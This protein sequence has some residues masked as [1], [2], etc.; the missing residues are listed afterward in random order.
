MCNKPIQI[1]RIW[2]FPILSSPF[3]VSKIFVIKKVSKKCHFKRW[4]FFDTYYELKQYVI[5]SRMR[6]TKIKKRRLKKK[7]SIILAI[8]NYVINFNGFFIFF[9]LEYKP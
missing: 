2:H 1:A 9:Y 8:I 4:Q 7:F 6:Y 3:W 5:L